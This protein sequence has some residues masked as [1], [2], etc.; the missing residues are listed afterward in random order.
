MITDEMLHV[1]HVER[2]PKLTI[3]EG[4]PIYVI[5]PDRCTECIWTGRATMC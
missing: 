5:D 3:E 4:D 2:V 1:M